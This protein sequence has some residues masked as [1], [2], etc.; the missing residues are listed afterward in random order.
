MFIKFE[1]LP[2]DHVHIPHT[3][4]THGQSYNI[5]GDLRSNAQ[6]VASF[7]TSTDKHTIY[8]SVYRLTN[9]T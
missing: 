5:I 9:I 3:L 2:E 4:L 6:F 8:Y 7:I 1:Y